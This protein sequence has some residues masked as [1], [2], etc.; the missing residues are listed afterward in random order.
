MDD[1]GGIDDTVSWTLL[2][3]RLR[4]RPRQHHNDDVGDVTLSTTHYH[5]DDDNVETTMTTSLQRRYDV[6]LDDRVDVTIVTYRTLYI[7]LCRHCR[8][9]V[10]APTAGQCPNER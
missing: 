3:S 8:N 1:D 5:V 2:S 10:V 4:R 9:V 7:L 6:V